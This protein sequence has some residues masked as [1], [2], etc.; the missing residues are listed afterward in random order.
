MTEG[1]NLNNCPIYLKVG[2]M[3]NLW[4][5]KQIEIQP[6]LQAARV[7]ET[8]NGVGN[9]ILQSFEFLCLEVYKD[10]FRETCVNIDKA[11]ENVQDA[12]AGE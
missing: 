7:A 8:L 1:N 6:H 11:N 4:T 3:S 9:I 12:P 10:T 5:Y 2:Y